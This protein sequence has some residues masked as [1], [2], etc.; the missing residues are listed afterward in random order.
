MRPLAV[1]LSICTIVTAALFGNAGAQTIYMGRIGVGY[2]VHDYKG[3]ASEQLG[4]STLRQLFRHSIDFG[5][6][7][8]FFSERIGY[9]SFELSLDGYYEQATIATGR[10]SNYYSPD[11]KN[12]SGALSLLPRTRVPIS[13]YLNQ[14]HYF[15]LNYEP[16]NRFVVI[17]ER[18]NLAVVRKYENKLQ[19]VGGE[20][21]FKPHRTL[22]FPRT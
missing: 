5:I 14:R 15:S 22:S 19:S 10:T 3:S 18:P 12:F 16:K 21:A 2:D 4:S 1:R 17:S 13:L 8:N 20:V 7:S 6:S 11:L 9:Y